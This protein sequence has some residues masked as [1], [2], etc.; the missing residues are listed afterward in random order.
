MVLQKDYRRHM[1]NTLEEKLHVVVW[2]HI[3]RYNI[4]AHL[5]FFI[6]IITKFYDEVIF[7]PYLYIYT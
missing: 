4:T 5:I 2:S 3:T 7:I 1:R 6:Y